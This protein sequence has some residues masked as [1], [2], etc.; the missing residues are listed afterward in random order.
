MKLSVVIPVFNEAENVLLLAAELSKIA[1]SFHFFEVLLVDDGSTDGTWSAIEQCAPD[2]PFVRGIHCPRNLGQ[3]AAL[4]RGIRGA[5]G[6][7]IVT[8]DGDLQNDPADIPRLAEVVGEYDVVCGYRAER[9][10]SWSRRAGSQLANYV[11]NRVTG[12][13]IIDT[14][15]SLKLFKRACVD[16]LPPLNGVHR[17]MPAYFMLHGRKIHQVAVNH[18]PRIHG[19]S[20]YT[21]LKRL[22]HTLRDLRGF[23]WYR[24]RF[25]NLSE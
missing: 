18:R 19:S 12:D 2:F 20:K 10:D 9:K 17:F 24:Q 22:P 8:L 7:W 16:D 5:K 4:L 11:R 25:L 13:G 14:G 3:S 23:A 1:D 15:C 21:N 6:D